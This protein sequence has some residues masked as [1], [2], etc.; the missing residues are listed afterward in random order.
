MINMRKGLVVKLAKHKLDHLFWTY[1]CLS[2]FKIKLME[3]IVAFHD[4]FKIGKLLFDKRGCFKF[5]FKTF[6]ANKY[7]KISERCKITFCIIF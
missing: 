4:L 2:G 6:A 5:N 7:R 1:F 3:F